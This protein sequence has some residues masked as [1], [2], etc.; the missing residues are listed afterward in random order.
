[1]TQNVIIVMPFTK[2]PWPMVIQFFKTSDMPYRLQRKCIRV[3]HENFHARHANGWLTGDLIIDPLTMLIVF[4]K[5]QI[6]HT[7]FEEPMAIMY[8]SWAGIEARMNLLGI[9]INFN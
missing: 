6:D 2:M 7:A 8:Q 3:I 4:N 9:D 5:E 1:M